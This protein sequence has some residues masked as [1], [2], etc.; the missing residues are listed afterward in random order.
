MYFDFSPEISTR[1]RSEL[2]P[3][4]EF[5]SIP[6]FW[7]VSSWPSWALDRFAKYWAS[8][9]SEIWPWPKLFLLPFFKEVIPPQIWNSILFS[10]NKVSLCIH[11]V[12]LVEWESFVFLSLHQGKYFIWPCFIHGFE[13]FCH[14][15]RWRDER[16]GNKYWQM[17]IWLCWE[18]GRKAICKNYDSL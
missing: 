2:H 6:L 7:G 4:G 3:G 16:E 15:G 5:F 10:K 18:F 17:F 13:V 9:E 12:Y 11:L 14:K 8:L 1:G